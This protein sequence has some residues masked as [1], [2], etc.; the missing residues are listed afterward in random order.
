MESVE[1]APMNIGVIAALVSVAFAAS[2]PFI[3]AWESAQT[4]GRNIAGGS[5]HF[6]IKGTLIATIGDQTATAPLSHN[7][8]ASV[9]HFN[10]GSRLI[11]SSGRSKITGEWIQP[12]TVTY[13]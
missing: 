4:F 2:S 8:S 9:F 6:E 13:G 12:P 7:A 5:V 11:V 1:R 3:G 10:D